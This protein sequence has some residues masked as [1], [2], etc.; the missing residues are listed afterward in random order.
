NAYF[1]IRNCVVHDGKSNN[2]HGIFFYSVQ[3]GKIDNVTSYNNLDGIY[4]Y[5]YSNNNQIS[6]SQ[7][8]NNY[9]GV[10]LDHFS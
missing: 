2:K 3:N 7:I 4:L 5:L 1:I 6:S 10:Y 8:Y 9:F